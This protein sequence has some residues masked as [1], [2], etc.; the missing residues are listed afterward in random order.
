MPTDNRQ[1]LP[2]RHYNQ[3]E[4]LM[5]ITMQSLGIDRLSIEERVAL[6]HAIWE[7][8]V[9]EAPSTLT[10]SQRLELKR[11]AA[12]DDASPDETV[13]WEEALAAALRGAGA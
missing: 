11:R 2:Y 8:V 4:F 6:T 3:L 1:C 13:S 7:S 12:E 5:P 9:A 10:E